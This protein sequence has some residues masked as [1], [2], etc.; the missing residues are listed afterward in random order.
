MLS[1]AEQKK[2]LIPAKYERPIQRDE[3]EKSAAP[4]MPGFNAKGSLSWPT[5]YSDFEFWSEISKMLGERDHCILLWLPVIPAT[6][7]DRL[8]L[9]ELNHILPMAQVAQPSTPFCDKT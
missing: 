5:S 3:H 4:K 1:G 9:Q 6:F 7:H 2:S 8:M